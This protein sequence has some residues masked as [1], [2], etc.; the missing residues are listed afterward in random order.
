MVTAAAITGRA[1]AGMI[2]WTPDPEMLNAI[3]EPALAFAYVIASRSVQVPV[4]VVEHP[5]VESPASLTVTVAAGDAAATDDRRR[6]ADE[7]VRMERRSKR[8]IGP[9][10]SGA[11][12][13][14]STIW[15]RSS[16]RV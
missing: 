15:R 11:K 3:V 10:I 5:L 9:S 14:P 12:A 8:L 7:T 4:P 6:K 1:A 16:V 2:V 13:G